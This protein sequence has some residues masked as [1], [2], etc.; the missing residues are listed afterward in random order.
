MEHPEQNE[1]WFDA[2]HN[3]AEHPEKIAEIIREA[4]KKIPTGVNK[5]EKEP[6]L[7]F[8]SE[9]ERGQEEREGHLTPKSDRLDQKKADGADVPER[10]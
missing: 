7:N 6:A 10:N 8:W 1:K 2:M 4:R 3:A 5:P 9:W